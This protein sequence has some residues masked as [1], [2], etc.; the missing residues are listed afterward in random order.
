MESAHAPKEAVIKFIFTLC[1]SNEYLSDPV[2]FRQLVQAGFFPMSYEGYKNQS[3]AMLNFDS[4]PWVHKITCPVLIVAGDEDLLADVSDAEMM[5][6]AIRKTE[7]YCFKKVGHIAFME[8]QE[9][10]NTLI[11]NFISSVGN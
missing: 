1:W 7:F 9:A 4:S 11:M 5:H 6:N 10:F 3:H 8:R 2:R